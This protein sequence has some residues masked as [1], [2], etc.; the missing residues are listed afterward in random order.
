MVRKRAGLFLAISYLLAGADRHYWK[1]GKV[2]DS[3]SAKAYF[4]TG[5]TTFSS[6]S[7]TV[8]GSS[9]SIVTGNMVSS[10]GSA[11]G[12]ARG[13]Q[14][15]HFHN[16]EIESTQLL[17]LGD[18][19]AY[20]I[21][22]SIEKSIGLAT[23]HDSL[24]HAIQNGK[25]GCRYIVGEWISYAHEGGRKLFINDVDGKT[26]KLDIVRQ[27]RLQPD[28]LQAL[29]KAASSS[30]VQPAVP[31]PATS[32]VSEISISSTPG[33]ADIMIDG[34]YMGSTPS[35]VPLSVGQHQVE[36]VK[37]GFMLWKREMTVASGGRVTVDA[38]LDKKVVSQ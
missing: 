11:T 37:P 26:C 2:L 5:A 35:I 29:E 27:E 19:Y 7:A 16:M 20:V 17:I 14:Q 4:Q 6:A 15:T 10:S 1:A 28:E 34:K 31:P 13:F 22:D 25:H 9:T 30:V 12:N 18:Q 38:T 24:G 21:E 32:G 36:I 23:L 3:Q 33:S 8:N